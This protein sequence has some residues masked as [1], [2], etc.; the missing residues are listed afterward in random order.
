MAVHFTNLLMINENMN[1]NK[2][3]YGW[4]DAKDVSSS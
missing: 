2:T 3:K 4:R 1:D